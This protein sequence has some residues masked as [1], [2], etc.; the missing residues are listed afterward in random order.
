MEYKSRGT[1]TIS[2]EEY[3]YLKEES[4][5]FRQFVKSDKCLEVNELSWCMRGDRRYIINPA[6]DLRNFADELS[7]EFQREKEKLVSKYRRRI[8]IWD[9]GKTIS[10][11]L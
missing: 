9:V 4:G 11:L 1:V 7:K 10:D 8:R 5:L 6:P 3:E 2:I